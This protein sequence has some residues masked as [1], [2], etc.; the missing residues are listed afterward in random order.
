MTNV[1]RKIKKV[2]GTGERPRLCVYR[3]GRNI[4]AQIID[5]AKGVTLV[6]SSSIEP[7]LKKKL[8]SG[9]SIE[10]AK[11]IGDDI[12]TKAKAKGIAKV[13]FDRGRALYHGRIK[14]LADSARAGGLQF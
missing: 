13:V 1:K 10:A 14:A 9:K 6:A 2:F 3:G 12:S 8:K 7:K 11:A 5:D 4:Y